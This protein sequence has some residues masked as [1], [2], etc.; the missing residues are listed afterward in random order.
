MWKALIEQDKSYFRRFNS[1]GH[2]WDDQGTTSMSYYIGNPYNISLDS[3][4]RIFR[5]AYDAIPEFGPDGR[6][7]H[8]GDVSQ[9]HAAPVVH[10]N[11]PTREALWNNSAWLRQH[12]PVRDQSK[13]SFRVN[14]LGERMTWSQLCGSV[15]E[16][17]G[18]YGLAPVEILFKNEE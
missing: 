17:D 6:F 7:H 15:P 5:V 13:L 9:R 8:S 10:F 12:Y 2:Y 18:R 3:D 1:R 11:G 4:Q 14:L 16:N